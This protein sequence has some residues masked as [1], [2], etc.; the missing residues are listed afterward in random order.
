MAER[1]QAG[2]IVNADDM[3]IDPAISA[4]ILSA[5]RSGIVSSTSLIV[6]MPKREAAINDVVRPSGIPVGLH[7]SLTEGR[8]IARDIPDLADDTGAFRIPAS[9]LVTLQ[10]G[11]RTWRLFAQIGTEITAQFALAK[12]HG[13]ALT[14][15]DSHQHVHMNPAIFRLIE[16]I[17]PRFGVRHMRLTREPAS[18]LLLTGELGETLL[19][20]NHVKWLLTRRLAR[21][22]RPQLETP[23]Q[24]FGLI[25]SGA[26]TKRVLLPFLRRAAAGRAIEI[27]IHPGFP[28][29]AADSTGAF[30]R[31]AYRQREHDALVDPEIAEIVRRRGLRLMAHG[32]RA[33]E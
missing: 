16:E 13:L 28:V 14:H 24:F 6:T 1:A 19:R 2:L 7:L 25:H 18:S 8:A 31:S 27:C 33:K 3:G 22:I 9:R 10:P 11:E 20:L 29:A 26:I 21:N 17:A 5:Y 23:E 4:G 30:Q 12:D 32:G 15:V